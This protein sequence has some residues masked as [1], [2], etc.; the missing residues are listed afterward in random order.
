VK[1]A[2][3]LLG[4]CS[5][6]A[7]LWGSV[8][9]SAWPAGGAAGG[10]LIGS[11]A[12]PVGTISGAALGATVGHALD[13]NA[14]LRSGELQGEG[15]GDKEIDRLRGRAVHAESDLT[16]LYRLGY[17]VLGYIV[18]LRRE[19]ILRAIKG[20]NRWMSFLHAIFAGKRTRPN[21]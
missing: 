5:G 7:G 3:L 2:L 6:C 9:S 11:A 19:W 4:L 8:K 13:E 1:R 12:G 15:A 16:L 21:V 14:Q 20:P 17:L 10:A 18:W